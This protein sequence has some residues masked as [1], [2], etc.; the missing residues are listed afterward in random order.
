LRNVIRSVLDLDAI[1]ETV[2]I[3]KQ[4]PARPGAAS[5]GA[6]GDGDREGARGGKSGGGDMA[7]GAGAGLGVGLGTGLLGHENEDADPR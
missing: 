3:P 5:K 7:T 6:R 1:A 4:G 2:A